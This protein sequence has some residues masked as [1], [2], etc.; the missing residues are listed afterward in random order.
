M[1]TTGIQYHSILSPLPEGFPA[2]YFALMQECW[3]DNAA[4]SPTAEHVH[5]RLL[6]MYPSA[7]AV[8][9]ALTLRHPVCTHAPASLLHCILAGMQAGPGQRNAH[10]APIVQ[11]MVADAAQIVCRSA[12]VKQHMQHHQVTEME[13]QTVSAYTI[14]A[15]DHSGLR[16]HYIYRKDEI[17]TV[18]LQKLRQKKKIYKF[19]T[20]ARP[21]ITNF[22]NQ[23]NSSK[24]MSHPGEGW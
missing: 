12:K 23:K 8:Q 1:S 4:Q 19:E 18:S 7:R 24:I 5:S 11:A 21:P 15:R 20:V 6:K 13:A 16:E 22:L 3:L 17:E 2:D 9:G 14:D 10:L